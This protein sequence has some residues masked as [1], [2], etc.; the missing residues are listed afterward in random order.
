MVNHLL[1][2]MAGLS[3]CLVCLEG[4]M[5]LSVLVCLQCPQEEEEG[6]SV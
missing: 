1:G 5:V 6:Q 3:R 2:E 4:E